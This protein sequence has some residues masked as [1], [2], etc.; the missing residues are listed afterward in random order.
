MKLQPTSPAL[1]PPLSG[2]AVRRAYFLMLVSSVSFASMTACARQAG[3]NLGDWRITAVARGA[4]VLLFA[5]AVARFHGVR[6]VWL[7][8]GTLWLRSITG[9]I[10]MLLTFFA[11][12]RHQNIS[13]A[14]TL[15][16]T[17]PLWVTLLAWPVL[18]ERPTWGAAFAL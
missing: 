7:R 15:T 13:T 9:S 18:R 2:P 11:L 17:F 6:L 14:L 16:S 10:S 8:P 12:T 3:Q 4:V 1:E 5:L